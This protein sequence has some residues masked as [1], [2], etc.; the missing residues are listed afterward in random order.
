MQ[1]KFQSVK[2]FS[3]P[4]Q[5]QAPNLF[6]TVPISEPPP[7]PFQVL[8]MDPT[9]IYPPPYLYHWLGDAFFQVKKKHVIP[10][11]AA[12]SMRLNFFTSQWNSYSRGMCSPCLHGDKVC[13][14]FA[15]QT[16]VP[17]Q[18]SVSGEAGHCVCG[19]A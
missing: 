17:F 8:L 7:P 1:L 2:F 19:C 9:L 5:Q 11:K 18:P 4:P 10:R 14:M 13:P 15:E 16:M 6:F 12:N 3:P